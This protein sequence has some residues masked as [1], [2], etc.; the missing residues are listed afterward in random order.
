MENTK[1]L[2]D[3]IHKVE[4][5]IEEAMEYANSY[6]GNGSMQ[7]TTAI[8]NAQY[9]IGYYHA[10]LTLIEELDFD[11]FIEVADRTRDDWETVTRIIDKIYYRSDKL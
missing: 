3:L 10:Y 6:Q 7:D 9:Y 5:A 4:N 11:R 8:L 2:K 1:I